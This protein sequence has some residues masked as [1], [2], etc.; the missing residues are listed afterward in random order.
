MQLEPKIT[1]F[2]KNREPQKPYPIPKYMI[3]KPKLG[4]P[5]PGQN[6]HQNVVR[7]SAAGKKDGDWYIYP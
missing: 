5:A 6:L 3:I 7:E 1:P 4:E 2:F